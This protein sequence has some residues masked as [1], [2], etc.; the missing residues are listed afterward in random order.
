MVTIE[1]PATETAAGGQS[2]SCVGE[3]VR[4]VTQVIE[5]YDPGIPCRRS[6]IA[7]F[8]GYTP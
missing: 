3:F 1:L 2:A 7:N 6:Q 8:T 4:Q 5:A